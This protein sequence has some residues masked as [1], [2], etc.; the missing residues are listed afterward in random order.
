MAHKGI[1]EYQ[2][3]QRRQ[4]LINKANQDKDLTQKVLEWL[5][6]QKSV[7]RSGSK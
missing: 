6:S 3:A 4:D 7:D 5:Q 1:K 2:E